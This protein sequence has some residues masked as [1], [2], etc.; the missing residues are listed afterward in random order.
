M[1]RQKPGQQCG[2]FERP[3][4]LHGMPCTIDRFDADV[5]LASPELL[6]VIGYDDPG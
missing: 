5:G 3:V 2:E 1:S 4:A 6:Y